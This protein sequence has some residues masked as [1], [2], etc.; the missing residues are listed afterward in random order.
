MKNE[1]Y[2][3]V[4]A[5]SIE[6]LFI[7]IYNAGP[8]SYGIGVWRKQGEIEWHTDFRSSYYTSDLRKAREGTSNFMKYLG[9]INVES[10]IAECIFEFANHLKHSK[11]DN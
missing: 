9:K 11:S 2:E 8:I 1:I 7:K 6:R 4:S 10:K 3:N 5:P